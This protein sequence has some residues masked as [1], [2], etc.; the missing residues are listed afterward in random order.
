MNRLKLWIFGVL[1]VAGT[2]GGVAYA[3]AVAPGAKTKFEA[4]LLF[5]TA[6]AA[7]TGFLGLIVSWLSYR[8][9]AGRVPKPDLAIVSGGELV[10]R[11]DLEPDGRGRAAGASAPRGRA[12][13]ATDTSAHEAPPREGVAPL[14]LTRLGRLSR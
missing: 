9:E 12:A 13:P 14:R 11:W 2:A 5:F 3:V 7:V 10:R 1:A 8:L 6:A 4:A